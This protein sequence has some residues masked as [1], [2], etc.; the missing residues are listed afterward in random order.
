MFSVPSVVQ[1]LAYPFICSF[2]LLLT[3]G[4]P[5][6]AQEWSRFRGPNGSGVAENVSF[7]AEWT[8]DDYLWKAELPGKG[9]GSPIGWGDTI[10][11]TAGD[12]ESGDVKLLALDVASGEPR[13][14]ET[15]PGSTYRMHQANSY[16]SSTPAADEQHVYLSIGQGRQLVVHAVTH[17]GKP[18]W[19]RNLGEYAGVH[20]FG[21]SPVVADGVVCVQCDTADG[22]FLSGLDA[23]SGKLLWKIERPPGKASYA[24]P[25]VYETAEQ[26][27]AFVSCSMEGGM[28]AI[29]VSSGK[30]LWEFPRVFPARTV[31]SPL[32]AAGEVFSQ[33]GGGGNGKQLVSVPIPGSGD[34]Q[35]AKP[36]IF[37][38]NIP[39]VP[40]PVVV[41]D[42]M[43]LWHDRGKVNCLGLLTGESLWVERVGGNY[44][45]SPIVAGDKIYCMS[46]DGE[47]VVI[48][49]GEKF[50]VLGRNAL[51]E[52]T[53][54][55][56]AV[57]K[58]K[59]LLRT[60]SKLFCLPDNG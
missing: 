48:S 55:T 35:P 4:S 40:T 54:A 19:K 41:E 17:D 53:N 21:V 42:R 57:F 25:C 15:F 38:R 7:P 23:A 13:W 20:G 5:C 31:S 52:P 24:T 6:I 9:H 29:E 56:P 59:L 51:D 43:Y 18:V 45:G 26:G 49:A 33:C 44:F 8:E 11:V 47:V 34:T 39:Y 50:E 22:G 14:T 36:A 60:E 3:L 16:A 28:Q 58:K 2:T 27:R 32:L 30:L 10:Y 1:I 46:V 12:S 37:S